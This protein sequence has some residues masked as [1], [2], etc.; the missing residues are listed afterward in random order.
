MCI[1]KCKLERMMS[2]DI[3]KGVADNE[4]RNVFLVGVSK[5]LVTCRLDHFSVG[6]NHFAAIVIFLLRISVSF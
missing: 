3:P 1:G 5:D 6:K 2:T 4:E